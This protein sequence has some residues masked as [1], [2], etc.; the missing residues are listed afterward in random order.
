MIVSIISEINRLLDDGGARRAWEELAERLGNQV[1]LCIDTRRRGV[2][3][4]EDMIWASAIAARDDINE[5]VDLK[6]RVEAAMDWRWLELVRPGSEQPR[7]L[8][9]RGDGELRVSPLRVR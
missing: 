3:I 1:I 5:L 7:R 2:R 4:G 6:R 9:L 8:E